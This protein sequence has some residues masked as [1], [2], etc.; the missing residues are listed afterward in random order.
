MTRLLCLVGIHD[1][2]VRVNL[3]PS[4][5]AR[6]VTAMEVTATC[7]GCGKMVKERHRIEE[8]AHDG[9]ATSER[10]AGQVD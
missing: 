6:V 1:Y 4:A 10:K 8:D 2:H 5:T 3:L 7:C 9:V